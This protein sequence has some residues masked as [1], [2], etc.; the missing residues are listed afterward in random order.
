MRVL[1]TARVDVA[2]DKRDA[3]LEGAKALIEETR[4]RP[5]CGAYHW[6]ADPFVSGRIHVFEA[7]LSEAD[8]AAHLSGPSYADMLA[9][10]GAVGIIDSQAHKHRVDHSEPVY[11]PSGQPRADFFTATD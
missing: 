4:A 3:A 2:P 9:H 1:I 6:T 10:L 5:G 8:F 11:D 7:W